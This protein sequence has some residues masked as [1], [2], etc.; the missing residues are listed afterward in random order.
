MSFDRSIPSRFRPVDGNEWRY[1]FFP[2]KLVPKPATGFGENRMGNGLSWRLRKKKRRSRQNP[3]PAT[4]LGKFEGNPFILAIPREKAT[5]APKPATRRRLGKFEWEPVYLGD[6]KTKRDRISETIRISE[7][8]RIDENSKGRPL[9]SRR[10]TTTDPKFWSRR[11]EGVKALRTLPFQIVSK[12]G[13]RHNE[14]KTSWS[15]NQSR[16]RVGGI[17]EAPTR[18]HNGGVSDRRRVPFVA[19]SSRSLR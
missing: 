19:S 10:S 16:R 1:R 8:I 18:R 14:S 15:G 4:G 6:R 13:P 2:L 11:S 7:A 17:A 12:V 5:I 3:R 9:P